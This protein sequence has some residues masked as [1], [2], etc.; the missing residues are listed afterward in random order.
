MQVMIRFG[1]AA[2]K[3]DLKHMQTVKFQ[4]S[5]RIGTVW[6]GFLSFAYTIPCLRY[7]TDSED[8]DPTRGC[9]K[10][11]GASTFF[12]AFKAFLLAIHVQ[13][14]TLIRDLDTH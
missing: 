5:L 6:S 3:R 11:S 14:K 10:W 9:A 1:L 8:L 7:M 2:E 12:K 13:Q 4:T